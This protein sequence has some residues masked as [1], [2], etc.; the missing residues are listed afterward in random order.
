MQGSE[1]FPLFL[2]KQKSDLAVIGAERKPP[3]APSSTSPPLFFIMMLFLFYFF[4]LCLRPPRRSVLA[5]ARLI[6]LPAGRTFE[7]HGTPSQTEERDRCFRLGRLRWQLSAATDG[8]LQPKPTSSLT[9]ASCCFLSFSFLR[10]RW[11]EGG[12]ASLTF[13]HPPFFHCSTNCSSH[14]CWG[15]S[16]LLVDLALTTN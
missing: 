7:E 5:A 11:R 16:G 1:E 15:A 14:C 8:A 2:E 9:T 10:C 6:F 12:R 13:Y 4:C 3:G